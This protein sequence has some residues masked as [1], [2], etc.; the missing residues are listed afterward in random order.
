MNP[1]SD[2][3]KSLTD[4]QLDAAYN[5]LSDTFELDSLEM[6][7]YDEWE[8]RERATHL[9]VYTP[10]LDEFR[11]LLAIEGGDG[12]TFL[13]APARRNELFLEHLT[14]RLQ[15]YR[16]LPGWGRPLEA[17]LVKILI[18]LAEQLPNPKE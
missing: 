16:L 9:T 3:V 13:Y 5:L 15:G 7:I 10:D 4:A 14:K 1:Y 11:R 12:E 17:A 2:F 6:A 18:Q 8:Q